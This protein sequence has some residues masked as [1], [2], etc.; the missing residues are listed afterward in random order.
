[1]SD[2]DELARRLSS[3]DADEA[4]RALGELIGQGRDA[5]PVLA[6]AA[7]SDS[8]DARAL[9]MEGLATVADPAALDAVRAGLRDPD[10]RVR[11]LAA[12]ALRRLGDPGAR[13]ALVAT[14]DDWPDVLHSH[15]SRSAYELPALGEDALEP[16]VPLLDSDEW[17]DRA[18]AAWIVSTVVS[19]ADD[20]SLDELGRILDGYDADGDPQDRGRRAQEAAEWLRRR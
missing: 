1:M 20:G 9:A 18:K 19:Q 3:E 10:G 4:G 6:E 15:L 7:R 8:A 11:S 14:L 17:A 13:H 12:V 5:T 16:V 2:R